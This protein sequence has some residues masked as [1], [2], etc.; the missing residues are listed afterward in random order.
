MA[1]QP[2]DPRSLILQL[3]SKSGGVSIPADLRQEIMR[4]IS[5][6]YTG[7]QTMSEGDI[8]AIEA[9]N[10]LK[11]AQSEPEGSL[12]K[13]AAS[14]ILKGVSPWSVQEQI[15][16][17]MAADP[18]LMGM[19]TDKEWNSFIDQLS[20]ENDKAQKKIFE[21]SQ[22]QDY[23]QKQ[24]YPGVGQQYN[25]Q[26]IMNL[27]PQQFST[28]SNQAEA[29]RPKYKA[30]EE[31][32]N[33]LYGALP[34][35]DAPTEREVESRSSIREDKSTKKTLDD[36]FALQRVAVSA[37]LNPQQ[38]LNPK[39]GDAKQIAANKKYQSMLKPITAYT[40][41]KQKTSGDGLVKETGKNVL[42]TALTAGVGPLIRDTVGLAK[43][44]VAPGTPLGP[45]VSSKEKQDA[46]RPQ[47]V[48]PILAGRQATVRQA[49]L[50]RINRSQGMPGAYEDVAAKLATG[51][52]QK[53]SQSG[54]NPLIDALVADLITKKAYTGGK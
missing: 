51:I 42:L 13:K 33:R 12:R 8:Y 7:Q 54:R 48:D 6:T 32:I 17:D 50:D 30:R 27:A 4:L 16:A 10:L 35:M 2:I 31:E 1:P 53:L 45:K 19:M 26:D 29:A 28:L 20:S 46:A 11:I 37:G 43:A 41:D 18:T 9:P 25:I 38:V 23:F 15:R 44:A 3:L 5:G 36:I 49:A 21:E 24:G 52:Q 14:L 40:S 39:K 47:V 34:M 22:K